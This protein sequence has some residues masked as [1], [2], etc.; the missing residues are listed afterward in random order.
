MLDS[1]KNATPNILHYSGGGVGNNGN[2]ESSS[3]SIKEQQNL[4]KDI[5]Q[6]PSSINNSDMDINIDS[7]EKL[8][9][10]LNQVSESLNVD[11][12]FAYN[13][14]IDEVYINVI[15]KNSG[16]VIRKLP[17]EE[18]M[19]IKETMKDWIGSLFDTKG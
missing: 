13:E 18:A 14:K 11:I 3:N 19:K 15:D 10:D 8:V 7:K 17:S 1:I 5:V 12:K 2:T 9:E 6:N 4:S 16:N